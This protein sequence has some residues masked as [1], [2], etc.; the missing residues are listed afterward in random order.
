MTDS[1][2]RLVPDAM[3]KEIDKLR[4]SLVRKVVARAEDASRTLR[5]FKQDAFSE[6]EAFCDLSAQEYDRELGGAKGNVSLVS[7]DGKYKVCRAI[8]ENL[9]FDERLQVA[10]TLIDKCIQEWSGGSR[11]ELQ[12]LINDAFQVDRLGNVNSKRILSL[13]KFNIEDARWQK[14][15]MAINDSLTVA[16]SS[17][18]LRVYERIE[19]TDKWRQLPLDLAGV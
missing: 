15:M 9:A 13:R 3:V 2:G 19:G 1:Q 16:S 12:V 18:Y 11:P 4:D 6:I 14:A 5:I 7:Y 17:V 10:K 8:A